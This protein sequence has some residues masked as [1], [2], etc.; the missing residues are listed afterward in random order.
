[1]RLICRSPKRCSSRWRNQFILSGGTLARC[2]TG[3][4]TGNEAARN[5]LELALTLLRGGDE[6][7]VPENFDA[8]SAGNA[9]GAGSGGSG[10]GF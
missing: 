8:G 7:V 5:N 9:S 10:S 4:D 6:R 2:P 1:M 3:T